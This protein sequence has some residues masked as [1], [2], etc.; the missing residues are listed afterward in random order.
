MFKLAGLFIV[1]ALIWTFADPTPPSLNIHGQAIASTPLPS[2][3]TPLM[4]LLDLR[5]PPPSNAYAITGN[6]LPP[7]L[8]AV[9]SAWKSEFPEISLSTN[10]VIFVIR[11]AEFYGGMDPEQEAWLTSREMLGLR[12]FPVV[13]NPLTPGD[14]WYLQ[15]QRE[16]K[17][18]NNDAIYILLASLFHEIAHTRLSADETL[19]YKEQLALFKRFRKQGKLKSPYAHSCHQALSDRYA[20]LRKH[21][22]Q[23]VQVHI[24]FQSQTVALLVR[25]PKNSPTAQDHPSNPT[26]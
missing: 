23:Y 25:S 16:W 18:G 24:R 22:D 4:S 11:P 19:A 15:A 13:I 6:Y 7:F 12:N 14:D 9:L 8:Q 21:P 20:D 10:G 26:F 1:S 5:E 3:P 17:R 2:Q